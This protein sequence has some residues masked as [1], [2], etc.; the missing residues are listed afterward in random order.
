MCQ[1]RLNYRTSVL[2]ET[3]KASI[4]NNNTTSDQVLDLSNKERI[5]EEITSASQDSSN[6]RAIKVGG[7][8]INIP[9]NPQELRNFIANL[10]AGILKADN[11][12]RDNFS[13]INFDKAIGRGNTSSLSVNTSSKDHTEG[14]AETFKSSISRK[15]F[16]ALNNNIE[17]RLRSVNAEI[18]TLE[19]SATAQSPETQQKI[20]ELR[21]QEKTLN[22][23][24]NIASSAQALS[25]SA[26]SLDNVTTQNALTTATQNVNNKTQEFVN[27]I[28]KNKSLISEDCIPELQSLIDKTTQKINSASERVS[29]VANPNL[30]SNLRALGRDSNPSGILRQYDS[31]LELR[32]EGRRNRANET[33]NPNGFLQ[34]TYNDLQDD[35]IFAK[36]INDI[37]QRMD[38]MSPTDARAALSEIQQ[39]FSTQSGKPFIRQ[40]N[41]NAVKR[42]LEAKAMA[43]QAGAE[44]N[45]VNSQITPQDIQNAQ[46]Q[47]SDYYQMMQ[48][49]VSARTTLSNATTLNNSVSLDRTGFGPSVRSSGNAIQAQTRTTIAQNEVLAAQTIDITQGAFTRAT[50]REEQERQQS[51]VN[52]PE[53]IGGFLQDMQ[54]GSHA[55][56]EIGLMG[57]VGNDMAG[58]DVGVKFGLTVEKSF[59]QGASYLAHADIKGIINA[60]AGIEGIFKTELELSVGL[61]G[62]IAFRTPQ[63]VEK[64][65]KTLKNFLNNAVAGKDYQSDLNE[66]KSMMSQNSYTGNTFSA[67]KTY[68]APGL[69]LDINLGIATTNANFQPSPSNG[70]NYAQSTQDVITSGSISYKNFGLS[71]TNENSRITNLPPG[72]SN[73]RYNRTSV[74]FRLPLSTNSTPIQNLQASIPNDVL[75]RAAVLMKAADPSLSSESDT[76]V[77]GMISMA[78]KNAGSTK[79]QQLMARSSVTGATSLTVNFTIAQEGDR[80]YS[81]IGLGTKSTINVSTPRVGNGV[82]TGKATLNA[83]LEVGTVVQ[84]NER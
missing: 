63:E 17:N 24:K 40:S 46:R 11:T 44:L 67:T 27:T 55:S 57:G 75:L 18:T 19:S 76:A 15:Q 70:V 69:G 77:A 50:V 30:K 21:N 83:E 84:T 33:A 34:S 62:G 14:L 59:G 9:T 71:V 39:I 38:R 3:Q 25:T 58:V 12:L 66:L 7:E 47:S 78:L 72:E 64:F 36:K 68:S 32:S 22:A 49:A 6:I 35:V 81:E 37:A 61:Q 48:R 82:L 54:N 45:A 31:F 60:H 20:N 26:G 80:R 73:Q 29:L 13:F 74:Q 5:A 42:I 41:I 4:V 79:L 23:Y 51:L 53:Q 8:L 1:I 10:K 56:F 52:N 2:N 65:T 16:S 43:N 28:N